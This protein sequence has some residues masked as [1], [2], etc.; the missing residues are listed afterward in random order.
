ML[1]Y[2]AFPWSVG[3]ICDLLLANRIWQNKQTKHINLKQKF[4]PMIRL[5][6][7]V[8]AKGFYRLIKVVNQFGCELMKRGI[9][10]GRPPNWWPFK[11][12]LGP[13]LH[14]E[15]KFLW[16]LQIEGNEFCQQSH[17]HASDVIPS[18]RP[19]A[20]DEIPFLADTLVTALWDTE[21]S[22]QL[23]QAWMPDP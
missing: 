14:L 9:K 10:L 21:Q 12:K 15:D 19:W 22:T 18:W 17:R 1:L 3:R 8:N 20:S 4:K 2:N 13:F 16:V 11:M 7:V 5:C 23:C 6:Y